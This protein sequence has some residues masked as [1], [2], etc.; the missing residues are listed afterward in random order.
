MSHMFD[1]FGY[2]YGGEYTISWLI[3]DFSETDMSRLEN[4][5]KM[6]YFAFYNIKNLNWVKIDFSNAKMGNVKDMSSMFYELGYV[7]SSNYASVNGLTIDFSN[8]ILSGVES[9]N[10]MFYYSLYYVENINWLRIDFSNAKM[11]NVKDMSEMFNQLGYTWWSTSMS[12]ITIDFNNAKMNN[13]T[14]ME[15]MFKESFRNWKNI[16]WIKIDFTNVDFSNEDESLEINMQKMFQSFCNWDNIDVISWVTINFSGTNLKRVGSMKE[17][18]SSALV[19]WKVVNWIKIDFTNTDISGV[20]NM[21]QMFSSFC[22]WNNSESDSVSISW[23]IISFR[24]AKLSSVEDM[25]KMYNYAFANWKSINNVRIDFSNSNF[26]GNIANNVVNM[27][28]MFSRFWER[29]YY[30][31]E[32]V[33]WVTIDFSDANMSRVTNMELMFENSFRNWKNI[34]WVTI[35]FSSTVMNDV[36]NMKKMFYYAFNWVKSATWLTIDFSNAKMGNVKDMSEM[37]YYF[38]YTDSSTSGTLSWVRIDFSEANIS[39]ITNMGNMFYYAFAYLKNIDWIEIDFSK[40][41]FSAEDENSYLNMGGMFYQTC[42][43]YWTE[44]ISWVI[45]DFSESD[46]SRVTDMKQMF[47]YLFAYWKNISWIEIDFSKVN[48]WDENDGWTLDMFQMFYEMCYWYWMETVGWIKIDFSESDMSRVTNMEEMFYYALSYY[49]KISWIE[50][51]FRKVDFGNN[52]SSLVMTKMFDKFC[53]WD[54]VESISWVTIDFSDDDLSRVVSME[55]MFNYSFSYIDGEKLDKIEINWNNTIFNGSLTNMKKMFYGCWLKNLDLS[56][57]DTKN[58]EDMRSM[59]YGAKNIQTIYVWKNF[60]LNSEI[61]SWDMFAW[62][63]NIVWWNGTKYT[64]D[65]VNWE[66]AVIDDLNHSWYFTN[67]LDKPYRIRYNLNGWVLSWEKTVYTQRDEFT[68]INPTKQW[69]NFVWWIWSNWNNPEVTV[70][71]YQW[72]KWDLIYIAQWELI[73]TPAAWGWQSITPETKE[74]EHKAAEE[75]QEQKQE[76]KQGEQEK[77]QTKTP[78]KSNTTSNQT[79]IQQSSSTSK[80]GTTTVDPEI[81]S[82]YE[83]AYE[84]NVTT[85]PSLDEANPDWPVTRGHLAKM[86]VN[87]VTNVLWQEIPEKIPSECRWNDW[88]WDWESEEIKDYA[89]KSCALWLMWLDMDKF[90][91]NMQVTRAQFG[92]I[93]SRLLWWKK[94]AWWTPY[95][96]KHLNALKENWIMTQIENP[97]RRVELRQWVWVMLMRSAQNK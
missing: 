13:V 61:N 15:S 77:E 90:L 88:R 48:F 5:G 31:W 51:N 93:M 60:I 43:G 89:V 83:W 49:K 75:K 14:N 35:D 66:Y 55:E 85:I 1:Q 32:S 11:G 6:F 59:F 42:Y 53:Y 22:Y 92:T 80:D 39:R 84:H 41:N 70:R 36:I 87:Y 30:N 57:F 29:N 65:H 94:Y 34:N 4:V 40:V 44:S 64:W 25:Q 9:M 16:N 63:E 27:K 12:W 97:E 79:S 10:Q 73:L 45:I 3:I 19:W 58:V 96:R 54:G 37:F 8:A 56:S 69:Y 38:F 81:R 33:N 52:S 23:A 78:E 21:S 82:A 26:S 72:T 95:Y 20:T 91:P 47:Y 76:T 68:L 67:I 18:F 74:Q 28:E 50:I 46:M 24:E 17:M 86:V 7:T 62:A 2:W 71:I